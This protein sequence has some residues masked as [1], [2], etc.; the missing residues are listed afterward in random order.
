MLEHLSSTTETPTS[1]CQLPVWRQQ[2]HLWI[3][4][5]LLDA[6]G[7]NSLYMYIVCSDGM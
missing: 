5:S 6:E 7:R 1:L 3:T 4:C 2:I